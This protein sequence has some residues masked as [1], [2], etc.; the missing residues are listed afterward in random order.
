MILNSVGKIRYLKHFI[1]DI[2]SF[3]LFIA[4]DAFK[5]LSFESRPLPRLFEVNNHE[6]FNN[7]K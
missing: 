5:A 7:L 1:K 2:C 3:K 4:T 6:E